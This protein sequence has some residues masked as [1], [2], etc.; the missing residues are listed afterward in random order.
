MCTFAEGIAYVPTIVGRLAKVASRFL[1]DDKYAPILEIVRTLRPTNEPWSPR[2]SST[3]AIRSRPCSSASKHSLLS[4]V[5]LTGRPIWGHPH[6]VMRYS[7]Y[8][9]PLYPKP[10]PTS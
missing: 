3:S 10:P 5:H 4:Q 8:S 2:A 7:I 6:T 1:S 9:H